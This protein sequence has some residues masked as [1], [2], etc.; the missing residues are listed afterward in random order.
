MKTRFLI[1]S[2]FILVLSAGCGRQRR[3]DDAERRFRQNAEIETLILDS[4]LHSYR[5]A[6]PE[7]IGHLHGS[8]LRDGTFA[9]IDSL[10]D[11]QERLIGI[12]IENCSRRS[13]PR[14]VNSLARHFRIARGI[15]DAEI[16]F[17]Y[18]IFPPPWALS[19]PDEAK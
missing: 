4:I 11:E 18:K 8:Y 7:R 19:G 2:L 17:V 1:P 6:S 12:L 15:T 16:P 3:F 10:D 14:L 5:F 13:V 9:L